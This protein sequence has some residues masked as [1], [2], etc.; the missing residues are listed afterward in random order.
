MHILC[1][2]LDK[3]ILS[4]IQKLS[5]TLGAHA[6][7]L[8]SGSSVNSAHISSFFPPFSSCSYIYGNT[9]W[10]VF[11]VTHQCGHT[12]LLIVG[13]KVITI[14]SA[15]TLSTLSQ[16]LFSAAHKSLWCL[17]LL[18]K[19][20]HMLSLDQ[21]VWVSLI[22]ACTTFNIHVLSKVT[23]NFTKWCRV[24]VV[25]FFEFV[26]TTL[27]VS[28]TFNVWHLSCRAST[29]SGWIRTRC[30]PLSMSVEG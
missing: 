27:T 18:F 21:L 1:L 12:S 8:L 11:L 6:H 3:S 19:V 30:V 10:Y 14:H 17:H 22:I 13:L 24:I 7:C 2:L 5:S 29:T 15:R 4:V 28:G 9:H 23:E 26:I 20:M 16:T 25:F